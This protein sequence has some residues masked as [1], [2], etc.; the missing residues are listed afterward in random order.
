MITADDLGTL[1]RLAAKPIVLRYVLSFDGTAGVDTTTGAEVDV[2][3]TE[4]VGVKPVLADVATL[5]AIVAH[6]PDVPE[7]VAAG[8]ALAALS[9]APATRLF[10]SHYEQTPA[11][12]ADIAGTVKSMRNQIRIVEQLVPLGLLAAAA[13]SLAVGVVVSWRR[14]GPM[15]ELSGASPVGPAP[16]REPV[17]SGNPR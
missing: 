9:S 10:E 5:Q 4:S 6:Y 15:S 13:L 3:A 12:V 1:A 17:S 14:R 16:Q 8:K 11:S 2:A 7:A